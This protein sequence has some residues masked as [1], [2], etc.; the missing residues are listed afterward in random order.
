MAA[1]SFHSSPSHPR[2]VMSPWMSST[3]SRTYVV[4]AMR[5]AAIALVLLGLLILMVLF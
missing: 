1:P 4:A 3:C 5:A 2:S